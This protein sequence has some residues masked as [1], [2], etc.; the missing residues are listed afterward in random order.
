MNTR[1]Y[2]WFYS[3]MIHDVYIWIRSSIEN[4]KYMRLGRKDVRER[5][6]RPTVPAMKT[7]KKSTW[8]NTYTC[9]ITVLK[10]WASKIITC[11]FIT[12]VIITT[13]IIIIIIEII[14]YF[15]GLQS[16]SGPLYYLSLLL[17][18]QFVSSVRLSVGAPVAQW[19]KR[20]PTGLAIPGPSP[21]WGEIFLVVNGVPLHTAFHYHPP[22]FLIWLENYWKG[23]KFA[24]HPPIHPSVRSSI[25]SQSSALNLFPQR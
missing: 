21:A 9:I 11:V 10:R 6:R 22:I 3:T 1:L 7:E 23:R 25:V 13:T 19:V 17:F 8:C 2:F 5:G 15:F 18:I 12:V 4:Y 24:P 20:W 14:L 16:C